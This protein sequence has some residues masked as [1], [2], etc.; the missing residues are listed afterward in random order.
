MSCIFNHLYRRFFMG[1]GLG[2]FR[3]GGGAQ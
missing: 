1:F 2:E 3:N